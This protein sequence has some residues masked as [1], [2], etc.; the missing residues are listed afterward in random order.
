MGMSVVLFRRVK[1]TISGQPSLE[2]RQDRVPVSHRGLPIDW[3]ITLE[4]NSWID[5]VMRQRKFHAAPCRIKLTASYCDSQIRR[6]DPPSRAAFC[7]VLPYPRAMLHL[8]GTGDRGVRWYVLECCSDPRDPLSFAQSTCSTGI[9]VRRPVRCSHEWVDF[10]SPSASNPG[11]WM[12][13]SCS[14]FFSQYCMS[15]MLTR[16][17]DG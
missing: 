1:L 15:L 12:W 11:N 13:L 2:G 9:Q 3:L 6:L 14:A 17:I 5:A 10:T 8:L 4:P 7:G 16:V